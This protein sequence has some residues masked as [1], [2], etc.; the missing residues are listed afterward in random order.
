[1]K[2]LG[3][4]AIA[5]TLG[6][7]ACGGSSGGN[8]SSKHT[9]DYGEAVVTKAAT[10]EEAGESVAKC[11]ICGHEKTSTIKAL[12][13][14]LGEATVTK[15]AT[16]EETGTQKAT[17]KRCNKEV[18]ETI[19]AKGHT[20]GEWVTVTEPDCTNAGSR[21]HT[22]SVCEKE[23]SESVDALGHNWGEWEVITAATCTEKGSRKHV[24]ERCSVEETEEVAA[25]GHD[26]QLIG[27]DTEPEAGK[28]KVRVYTCANECG[29][30]YLGF[31]ANEVS[32][33]SKEHLSFT[34]VTNS[35]GKKEIGA[36]FWGRPIG[37]ALALKADGSSQNEQVDECVY[38]S[39]ET[40]DFFEY[41]FDLT[42]DQVDQ[43][44]L[45]N[46]RLWLDAKPA[47]YMNGGD[48]F[49]YGGGNTDDWTPGFYID[50]ADDHI[51]KDD[52]G[53]PVMVND[54]ARSVRAD[55]GS[56]AAG[57]QLDTQVPMGKRITDYR[58]ILY[59]DDQVQ[60]FEQ[61]V[62]NLTHGSNQNMT[63]EEFCLPFVFKL[64]AGEN[65]I[66]LGMA[67]GYRS[68]FFN[69]T[70][71]PVE[72]QGQ[73]G[74]GGEGGE[75]GQ[76]TPVE[77]AAPTFPAENPTP[78]DYSTW[79]EGTPAQNKSG[80]TYTPLAGADK[81]G[82]KIAF[83]DVSAGTWDGTKLSSSENSGV[84]YEVKA[85]KA[86][87]YQMIMK[88]KVSSSG[89]GKTFTERGVK[90]TVNTWASQAN[91]YGSRTEVEAGLNTST[92]ELFVLAVVNLT[93]EED[94]IYIENR[95][96]RIDFDSAAPV[97][98]AEI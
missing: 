70:F 88:A 92:K 1:M 11:K 21:K 38:C 16:C 96:Y 10:C 42:Q 25:L 48:F 5:L 86:G 9:H 71:R 31:K 46:C 29:L 51:E 54:H 72:E 93:G 75:G 40:G 6:L 66:R 27:D 45:D 33:A 37:N 67:G 60:Q 87:L 13:H 22:C 64:H 61:G 84:T 80:K 50:G 83:A 19:P 56:E 82:V 8:K 34:E 74:E 35:E 81:A 98:F 53:Q 63:R 57:E 47:N 30:T 12:G 36:S 78:I 79:T 26:I 7:T 73:G 76:T 3:V 65:K 23:E 58:Y 43:A 2:I 97:V 20:W 14:D 68:T 4:L 24:C 28:A 94:S 69:F 18:E 52:Q 55:D 41:I 91:V 89:N 85:P 39:T 90:V 44:G 32:E 77:P 95:Y 49:A 59:V 62:T 15:E 17:C